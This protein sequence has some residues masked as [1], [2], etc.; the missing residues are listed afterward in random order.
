MKTIKVKDTYG[1]IHNYNPQYVKDVQEVESDINGEWCLSIILT[2]E[3]ERINTIL[4][5]SKEEMEV[6]RDKIL[7]CIESI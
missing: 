5:K 4:F 3:G 7:A 6:M 2:G 1:V